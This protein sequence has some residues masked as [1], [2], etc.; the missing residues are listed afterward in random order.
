[1]LPTMLEQDRIHAGCSV[2]Q[3]AWRLGVTI[4]EYRELEALALDRLTSRLGTGRLELEREVNWKDVPELRA[5]MIHRACKSGA[6]LSSSQRRATIA[7]ACFLA[8][9]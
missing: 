6:L 9:S 4:R 8:A 2:G 3:A 5:A 1:M 7:S